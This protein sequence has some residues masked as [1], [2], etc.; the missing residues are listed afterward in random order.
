M[1]IVKHAEKCSD[2]TVEAVHS[3]LHQYMTEHCYSRKNIENSSSGEALLRAILAWNSYVLG[4]ND[5]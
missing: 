2:Q 1:L 5:K 3:K 4:D